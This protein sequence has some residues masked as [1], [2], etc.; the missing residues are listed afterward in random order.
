MCYASLYIHYLSASRINDQ[1]NELASKG[2][3]IL[4]SLFYSSSLPPF[5]HMYIM[6][7]L[8]RYSTYLLTYIDLYYFLISYLAEH[9]DSANLFQ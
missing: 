8:C 3:F 7:C 9:K 1:F 6:S 5:N 2:S 4:H